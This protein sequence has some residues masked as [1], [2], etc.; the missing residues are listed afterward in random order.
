M[1]SHIEEAD[2][3]SYGLLGLI[4]ALERFDPERE[5]KFETYAISRIKGSTARRSTCPPTAR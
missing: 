3:I 1:P 2:L 4:G 5:I